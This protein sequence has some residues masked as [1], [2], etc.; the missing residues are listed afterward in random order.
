[1]LA[2]R[3]RSVSL[4]AVSRATLIVIYTG[5]SLILYAYRYRL[6]IS[7]GMPIFEYARRQWYDKCM[8]GKVLAVSS[9]CALAL[10]SALMQST[11]PSSIHPL[12][13]LAVFVLIYVLALGVLTFFVFQGSRLLSRLYRQSAAARSQITLRRAY[14]YASVVALAPVMIL[15]IASIGRL[16]AYQVLLI[17]LFEAAACFY[18]AKRH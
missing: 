3:E 18:V 15:G 8:L 1:M 16:D 6:H 11:T 13:I 17:L 2:I 5:V 7:F 9:I 10:L 12:G 14:L 4:I